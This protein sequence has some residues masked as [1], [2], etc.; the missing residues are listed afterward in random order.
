MYNLLF[1][2][3]RHYSAIAIVIGIA[4]AIA[5]G[6]VIDIA[7]VISISIV[8]ALALSL[9]YFHTTH[10]SELTPANASRYTPTDTL[11]LLRSHACAYTTQ[12]ILLNVYDP[13]YTATLA[14]QL[15]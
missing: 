2:P 12:R 15:A 9:P 8:I 1:I 13:T 4:I 6:I 3:I 7:I 5:I 10:N 11:T 14:T